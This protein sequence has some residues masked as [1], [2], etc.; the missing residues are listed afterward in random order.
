VPVLDVEQLKNITMDD[1]DLMRE[2]LDALISDTSR[3]L[4]AFSMWNN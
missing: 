2:I 4:G 3:Q 1:A